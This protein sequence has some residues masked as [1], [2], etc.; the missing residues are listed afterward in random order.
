MYGFLS[1]RRGHRQGP[2]HFGWWSAFGRRWKRGK[3]MLSV[4]GDP[5]RIRQAQR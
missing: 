4:F 5:A 3:A 1:H 2:L